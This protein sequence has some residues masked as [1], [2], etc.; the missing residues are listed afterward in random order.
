LP[1]HSRLKS[2]FAEPAAHQ[3]VKPLQSAASAPNLI[4]T[5]SKTCCIDASE[6]RR[7]KRGRD[8]RKSALY[9]PKLVVNRGNYSIKLSAVTMFRRFMILRHRDL[10]PC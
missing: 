5:S 6:L 1:F 8:N 7:E 2:L 4:N 3:E 9:V 10:P